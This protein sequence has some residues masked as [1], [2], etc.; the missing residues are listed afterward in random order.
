MKYL[1]YSKITQ[2]CVIMWIAQGGYPRLCFSLFLSSQKWTFLRLTCKGIV[3]KAQ[4]ALHRGRAP[5]CCHGKRAAGQNDNCV[6]NNCTQRMSESKHRKPLCIVYPNTWPST[7]QERGR[8]E[9]VYV[10]EKAFF[11]CVAVLVI[12]IMSKS[13]GRTWG[14]PFGAVRGQ[15]LFPW[16]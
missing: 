8:R 16:M 15:I 14:N 5:W 12:K 11:Q 2:E 6:S 4:E 10:T 9:E 3:N 13:H 1:L 7:I